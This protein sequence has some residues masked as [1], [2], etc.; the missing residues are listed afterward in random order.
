[1]VP[2]QISCLF[3]TAGFFLLPVSFFLAPVLHVTAVSLVSSCSSG[4]G[5]ID[6][7]LIV[8]LNLGILNRPLA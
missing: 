6:L 2:V 7:L 3:F 5:Y 4:L 8:F 1:M